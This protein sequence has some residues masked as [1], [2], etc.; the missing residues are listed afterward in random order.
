MP[1]PILVSACLLGLATRYDGTAK[2]NP[3]VLA[4]LT[5]ESR[6][7]IPVCPEQLGGL[8][9]PRPRC[10]FLRGDG[11]AVVA[12][13]GT[14]VNAD[15]EPRN[16]VFLRA[17][18]ATLQLAQLTGCC[19]ALFKEGSPSCGCTRIDRNGERVPGMGVTTALLRR[20]KIMVR[21][22]SEL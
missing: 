10:F 4:W 9:T 13:T 19:E 12:G 8:P 11:A 15:E 21:S 1:R 3:A 16:E 7:P 5:R 14:V 6:Q 2:P 22:E 20:N 17:A 18:L